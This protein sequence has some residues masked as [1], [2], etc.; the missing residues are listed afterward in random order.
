MRADCTF[1]IVMLH[2][3]SARSG[4]DN[5]DGDGDQQSLDATT[6]R[7]LASLSRIGIPSAAAAVL[8][9]LYFDEASRLIAS[10]LDSDAIRI[11][12]TDERSG[13]FVQDFLVVVD[14]LF[15]ILAG[16]AYSRLYEQQESIYV[17]LYAEVTVAKSLLEQLT[18]VGQARP[19]YASTLRSMQ[20][21]TRH[22]LRRVDVPPAEALSGRPA[23]D[24]LEAIMRLTSVGVPS[25][26]YETVKELRQ[27]RGRRLGAFQGKFPL[28]G[29]TLLYLLAA[30]ELL[31]FPLLGA[32]TAGLSEL[33]EQPLVSI[34]ELQALVFAVLAGCLVLVLRII[35]EHWQ[36]S[37]GIFNVDEV[38]QQMVSGLEEELE[39]RLGGQIPPQPSERKQRDWDEAM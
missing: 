20:W 21:Y 39:L 26:L 24:P 32:G 25:S 38:L 6:R 17:A 3:T 28:L 22:D 9:Y 5:D 36:L 29:I 18:L 8:A 30:V 33:P 37:G 16:N 34:L 11:I 15:A 1:P 7:A 13:Q 4:S 10:V 19:W 2:S 35:Q 23:E 31:S 12:S 14:L 27:A